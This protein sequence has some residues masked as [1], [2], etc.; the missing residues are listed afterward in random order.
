MHLKRMLDFTQQLP[1]VTRAWL[2]PHVSNGTMVLDG[3]P[4]DTDFYLNSKFRV[5][6]LRW[7]GPVP[8]ARL[9]RKTWMV[10]PTSPGTKWG[11]LAFCVFP[12]CVAFCW[13]TLE[14]TFL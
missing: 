8:S 12:G 9:L 7:L 6:S 13:P 3:P 1:S 14:F 11:G 5:Y 2:S 4:S 10:R